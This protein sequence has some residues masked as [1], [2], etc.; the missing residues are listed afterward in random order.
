MNWLDEV[1][2]RIKRK[3]QILFD[4]NSEFLADLAALIQEQTHRTMVL[5]AFE[6]ADEAVQRL[7]EHYPNE[8]RLKTAVLLSKDWAAGKV[9]MPVAKRA[10]L[11]AHK[12]AKEI[13]SLE[14]I[15]LCHAIGQACGV[16]HSKGHA[17]GFPIYELTAIVRHYGVPEC[18]SVVEERKQQYIERI[19]YWRD[20]FKD[21]PCEWADF[22]M[23][24]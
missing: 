2:N 22:M 16:V 10:I 23:K 6:F 9:K 11:Q 19:Y 4:K 24:D 21:Y 12:V 3:N 20:H 8:K 1:Q 13:E 15:A 14:D 18:K 5:W 17:I 7:F